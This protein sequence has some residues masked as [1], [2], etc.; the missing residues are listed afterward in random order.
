MNLLDP[1][2]LD[3]TEIVR[4]R[5]ILNGARYEVARQVDNSETKIANWNINVVKGNVRAPIAKCWL[6]SIEGSY[7]LMFAWEPPF[8]ESAS[9]LRLCGLQVVV[10]PVVGDVIEEKVVMLHAAAPVL[11]TEFVHDDIPLAQLTTSIPSNAFDTPLLI[12]LTMNNESVKIPLAVPSEKPKMRVGSIR[13]AA[14]VD[15]HGGESLVIILKDASE[16]PG[17]ERRVSL[18]IFLADLTKSVQT[19]RDPGRSLERLRAIVGDRLQSATIAMNRLSKNQPEYEE[20]RELISQ[21]QESILLTYANSTHEKIVSDNIVER[22]K[23][24]VSQPIAA[25]RDLSLD[26]NIKVALMLMS[27][28][29]HVTRLRNLRTKM[30]KA[31]REGKKQEAAEIARQVEVTYSDLIKAFS[32][33]HA[34]L[35]SSL[36]DFD[37]H[38]KRRIRLGHEMEADRAAGSP[39][40]IQRLRGMNRWL[41]QLADNGEFEGAVQQSL[42]QLVPPMDVIRFKAL[43]SKNQPNTNEEPA[44]NDK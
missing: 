30:N 10:R 20:L 29:V 8:L 25:W 38:V 19:D 27:D 3:I 33:K 26:M 6:E 24:F 11:A 17:P 42:G 37:N 40:R 35:F 16:Q 44:K 7:V 4:G 31:N 2:Q 13:L 12:S 22:V 5:R 36:A 39:T 32:E 43:S 21:K 9:R 28:S 15:P 1:T 18:N 34:D 14:N 23:T 41:G